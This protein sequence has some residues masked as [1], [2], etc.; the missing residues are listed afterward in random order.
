M[1]SIQQFRSVG[2]PTDRKIIQDMWGRDIQRISLPWNASNVN[3]QLQFT[4]SGVYTYKY[5]VNGIS[6]EAGKLIIS[7]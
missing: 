2:T 4:A 1:I 6:Q 3:T 5:V 7:N